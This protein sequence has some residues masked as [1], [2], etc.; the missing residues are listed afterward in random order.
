MQVQWSLHFMTTHQSE[1][2]SLK[3]KVIHKAIYIENIK[4]KLQ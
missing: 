1:Q 2:H 4:K 3:L